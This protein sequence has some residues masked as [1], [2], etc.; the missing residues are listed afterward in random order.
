MNLACK[1]PVPWA[2][3][4]EIVRGQT[5]SKSGS[6]SLDRAVSDLQLEQAGLHLKEECLKRNKISKLV[7]FMKNLMKTYCIVETNQPILFE[8]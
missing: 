1:C 2:S 3:L 7:W 5:W 6:G 4:I 8:T